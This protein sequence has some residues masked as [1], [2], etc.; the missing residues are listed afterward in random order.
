MCNYVSTVLILT[1]AQAKPTHG[2]IIRFAPPMVITE[3]QLRKGVSIIAEALKELPN[4]PK[5]DH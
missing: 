2:D 1:R 4:T 3:E 5:A